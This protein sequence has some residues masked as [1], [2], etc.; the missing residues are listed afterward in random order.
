MQLAQY[1]DGD[2]GT[3][4]PA[5]LEAFVADALAAGGGG[6]DDAADAAA[7]DA[8]DFAAMRA[9]IATRKLLFFHGRY[10]LFF[11]FV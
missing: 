3:L 8:P 5:A 1:E 6:G 7:D 2:D 9:A 4:S 11:L 10:A